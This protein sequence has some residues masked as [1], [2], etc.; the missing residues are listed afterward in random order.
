MVNYRLF[1]NLSKPFHL[2]LSS[3]TY[4]LGAGMAHYLGHPFH[5]V[6]F[7]MGLL[8]VL[9]IQV[10][11]HWL[12]EYF[13]LAFTTLEINET[14][15][16]RDLFRASLLYSA[17]ALLTVA[18]AIIMTLGLEKLL[19]LPVWILLGLI[20]LIYVAYAI[21][22]FRL[23]EVGYGELIQAIA[24][25][26]LFPAFA[27]HIQFL[28][29]HRLV[30]FV[31]FPLTLLALAYFLV[32]DFVRYGADIRLGRKTLLTR[33]SWQRAIPIHHLLV[34]AAF[35]L[36]AISPLFGFPWGLIWPVYL[37]LPFALFQVIWLQNIAR[38]GRAQWKIL[39][40][41]S[42]AVFGLI[43][44]LLTVSFWIR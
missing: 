20:I 8:I 3:L 18:G 2:L 17:T 5:A 29:F 7:G 14:H 40:P 42:A 30:T 9:V 44:Y 23:H 36:F 26:T 25:G 32:E 24:L 33:L 37:A 31:T 21:P 39:V 38:G 35:L 13:R 1:I 16:E 43:G 27:F 6:T 22:P 41:F 4:T 10:A 15:R 28:E 19:M 12:V 34:L 11:G